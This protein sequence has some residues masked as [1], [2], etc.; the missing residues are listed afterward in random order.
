MKDEDRVRLQEL[1][2]NAESPEEEGKF[3]EGRNKAAVTDCNVFE[4]KKTGD[5][6]LVIQIEGLKDQI[7]IRE[8]IFYRMSQDPK[9][10]FQWWN[11]MQGVLGIKDPKF[12]K[13][14][15]YVS[16]HLQNKVVWINVKDIKSPEGKVWR[17]ISIE[18]VVRAEEYKEQ[19]PPF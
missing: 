17:N 4:S 9:K 2:Q 13:S 11:L 7:D 10:S 8:P 12:S 3:P 19:K 18:N 16:E 1:E 15:E 14:E 6:Y 5:F